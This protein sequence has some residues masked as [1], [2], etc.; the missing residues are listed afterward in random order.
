MAKKKS[1]EQHPTHCPNSHLLSD[2]N[3]YGDRKCRKCRAGEAANK[4]MKMV[5]TR[6]PSRG[7][8]I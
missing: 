7:R 5:A 2:D 4:A 6:R 1:S 8:R 3:V